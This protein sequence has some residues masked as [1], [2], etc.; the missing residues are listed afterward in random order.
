MKREYLIKTLI[1]GIS[2]VDEI[3]KNLVL[4]IV[5]KPNAIYHPARPGSSYIDNKS[6]QPEN[7][8]EPSGTDTVD[9]CC[10]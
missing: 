1:L 3:P 6:K 9:Y 7:Q 4:H 5:K 10:G 2:T 8:Q